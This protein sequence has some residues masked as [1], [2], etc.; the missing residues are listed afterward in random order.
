[1][2][3]LH[4]G[5]TLSQGRDTLTEE[6]PSHRGRE[7]S[8]R[9]GVPHRRGTLS[10]GE[11]TLSQG[12]ETLSQGRDTL[13]ED[14]CPS[15]GRDPLIGG[16]NSLTGGGNSLTG[17]GPL[18]QGQDPPHRGRVSLTESESSHGGVWFSIKGGRVSTQ[19]YA[20]S[21]EDSTC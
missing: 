4:R 20:N 11:G 3:V 2:G 21:S 1:M 17:A 9:T 18:S 10:Q 8:Q 16:G 19:L 12:E 14:G 5:G 6:G 7:L 13:T 15:K